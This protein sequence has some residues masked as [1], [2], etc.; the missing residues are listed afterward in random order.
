MEISQ[1][2]ID[3][4]I[5]YYLKYY[6]SKKKLSKKLIDKFWPNSD[7]GKKYWGIWDDEIS[8]ILDH[9]MSSIIDEEAVILSKIR[10]Y[11]ARWKSKLYIKQKL[12]ERMEPVELI[13]YFLDIEFVDWELDTLKKEYIKTKTKI[14]NYNSENEYKQKLIQKLMMKGFSYDDIKQVI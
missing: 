9:K 4:S 5:W 12:Y 8:Y 2:I 3:Y 13:N 11:K 6:P 7:N 1:K 14:K 10:S